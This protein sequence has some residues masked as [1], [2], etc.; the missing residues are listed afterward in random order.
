[1]PNGE[2]RMPEAPVRHSGF[3]IDSDF[4]FRHS[5]FTAS[6]FST[7]LCTLQFPLPNALRNSLW[8]TRAETCRAAQQFCAFSKTPDKFC[9]VVGREIIRRNRKRLMTN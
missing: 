5:D 4:G 6:N 8:I 2:T 3:V 1:M 7:T 9:P